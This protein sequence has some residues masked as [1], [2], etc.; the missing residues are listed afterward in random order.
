MSDIIKAYLHCDK[1]YAYDLSEKSGLERDD[2]LNSLYEVEF[3][4]D[5]STGE[6]LRVNGRDLA[7]EEATSTEN[8]ETRA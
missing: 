2:I 3:E 5:S 7:P 8:G 4:L 1:D 6:I